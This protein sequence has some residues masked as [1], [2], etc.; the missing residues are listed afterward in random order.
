VKN[1]RLDR[2]KGNIKK[3]ASPN[4]KY[5]WREDRVG[6]GRKKKKKILGYT[7]LQEG[8]GEKG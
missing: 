4:R 2:G 7:G 6:M 3:S 1:P 5:F 8:K